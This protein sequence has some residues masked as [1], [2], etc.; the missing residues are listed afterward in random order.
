MTDRF[1]LTEE[2]PACNV[3][4]EMFY[5]LIRTAVPTENLVDGESLEILANQIVARAS[6]PRWRKY[7]V[8]YDDIQEAALT[9]QATLFQLPAGGVIHAV[10][11]KHSTAFAGTGI[12]AVTASVGVSSDS[13]KYAVAFDILQ[14]TG[15]EVLQLST[16]AGAETHDSGGTAILAEFV[17]TGA[18]L[19]ELTA[20]SVDIWVLYSV[21]L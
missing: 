20:G 6:V 9:A 2:L 3:T 18:N 8:D 5:S 19:E 12:S 17:S 14:A 4:R 13:D 15:N 7:T 21:T 11:I 1:E 16:T 10:K